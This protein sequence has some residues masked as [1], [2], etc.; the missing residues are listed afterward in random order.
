MINR[1]VLTGRLT[2]DPELRST[3]TGVNVT[4]FTIA[5]DKQARAGEKPQAN[6]IDIVAWR[7]TAEFVCRYFH[8]G[9]M[10]G[11]DG[12]ID[13]NRYEDRNGNKRTSFEIIAEKVSFCGSKSQNDNNTDNRQQ[14]KQTAA[15][16]RNN[17]RDQKNARNNAQNA[18]QTRPNY[19]NYD[20]DCWWEDE[21]PPY[22]H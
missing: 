15:N 22:G 17:A 13:T 10:I 9:S 6:F 7:Q 21:E 2:A 19:N 18:R 8:K 20:N 14:S 16:A 3:N 12:T 11:I 5:V 1:A 4:R